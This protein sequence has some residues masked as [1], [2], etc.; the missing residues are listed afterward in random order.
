VAKL[1]YRNLWRGKDKKTEKRVGL[2]MPNE[3]CPGCEEDVMNE[4][5]IM[6][7]LK[8]KGVLKVRAVIP[9]ALS[10]GRG[11][12]LVSRF[13]S[14]GLLSDLLEKEW[15][16]IEVED[17]TLDVKEEC[18]YRI[19]KAMKYVHS[20]NVIH[21]NLKPYC[22][23]LTKQLTPVIG[24]FSWAL[25]GTE[26]V[27]ETGAAGTPM[28]M[29]PEVINGEAY[30]N[31]IDVFSF[32][33]LLRMMFTNDRKMDDDKSHWGRSDSVKCMIRVCNG[34][35]F[36]RTPEIPSFYWS[37]ITRCWAQLPDDRPTFSEIVLELKARRN[38]SVDE[39]S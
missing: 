14:R 2:W 12:I 27:S 30:G 29:A 15:N 38:E 11:P 34:V 5:S 17:W 6:L 31:K 35:R 37:L 26:R 22:I 8:H 10:K 25:K 20:K 3:G 21:R 19:A 23:F 7:G 13:Y 1:D 4:A 39:D 28:F 36:R 18:I 32:G 33:V 9:T 24:D 16:G